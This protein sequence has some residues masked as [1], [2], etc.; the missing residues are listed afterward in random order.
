VSIERGKGISRIGLGPHAD[1]AQ[2][3]AYADTTR[4]FGEDI[5][6]AYQNYFSQIK[7][8]QGGSFLKGEMIVLIDEG[9]ASASEMIASALRYCKRAILLGSPSYGKGRIQ[10]SLDLP[11]HGYLHITIG[12]YTAGDGRRIDKYLS[13]DSVGLIPDIAAEP[14]VFPE[15]SD[16]LQEKINHEVASW[17]SD[18]AAYRRSLDSGVVL[19]HQLCELYGHPLYRAYLSAT[20]SH[21]YGNG[22][23]QQWHSESDTIQLAWQKLMN[24]REKPSIAQGSTTLKRSAKR[25]R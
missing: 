10:R 15:L 24:M 7:G 6:G 11:S 5:P 25:K 23:M 4:A 13:K 20:L 16:A 19:P 3:A 2:L 18:L 22:Y 14:R 17:F 21:I 12:E 1:S 9:S 8:V